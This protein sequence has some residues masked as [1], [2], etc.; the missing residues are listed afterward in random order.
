MQIASVLLCLILFIIVVVV[1][2]IFFLVS[3]KKDAQPAE[4]QSAKRIQH[5]SKAWMAYAIVALLLALWSIIAA[6]FFLAIVW[7][8]RQNPAPGS[9]STISDTEKRTARRVY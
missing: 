5:R 4:A 2:M 7:L 9:S 3:Q 8:M 6:L 1:L